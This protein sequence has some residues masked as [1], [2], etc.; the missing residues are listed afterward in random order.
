MIMLLDDSSPLVRRALA[1]ALAADE[2]AP[3][4]V[5][6]ALAADQPDSEVLWSD[7][8]HPIAVKVGGIERRYER[9]RR[10]Q[11]HGI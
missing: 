5:V 3:R 7:D 6:Q 11:D 9:Q 8:L 1:E 2:N 4:V 10:S